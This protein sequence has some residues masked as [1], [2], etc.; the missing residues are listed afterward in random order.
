MTDR[1]F[2]YVIIAFILL[3]LG[4]LTYQIIRPFLSPIMWSIVLSIVF[5]PVFSFILRFVKNRSLASFITLL[6]IFV[7]LFGPFSYLSYLLTQEVMSFVGQLESG[8]V[9]TVTGFIKHPAASTLVKKTLSLLHITEKEFQ[10][11]LIDGMAKL[12]KESAGLLTAGVGN[13]VSLVVNFIFTI[14][15]TFFFLLDGPKFISAVSSIIPFSG[16]QR[17]KLMQQ[18]KDVV[19]STIYGGVTVAV[20]QGLIGGA[21]FAILG[22]SSPILWGTAMFMSSFIP[23]VGTFLIWGPAAGYLFL[24]GFYIKGI[25]LVL[26]GIVIISSADNIIRPLIMKGRMKMPTIAIFF[27]I[28][29]GIK[30]FGFIGLIMG[31]LVLALFVSVFEIFKYSEEEWTRLKGRDQQ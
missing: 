11:A 14:L 25:I 27:S 2:Y 9:D 24:Q 20:A 15:T 29:G 10:K 21:T 8:S 16:E 19:V 23:M 3:V 31:P 26:V 5:Y 28:L 17:R 22:L 1:K 30:V 7:I 6:T 12:G 4:Y 13:A 18:T